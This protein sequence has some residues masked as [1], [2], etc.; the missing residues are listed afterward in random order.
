MGGESRWGGGWGE[1]MGWAAEVRPAGPSEPGRGE[2]IRPGGESCSDGWSGQGKDTTVDGTVEVPA[3]TVEA[4][5]SLMT[6]L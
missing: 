1:P 5:V 2:V 6:W 3:G 4:P